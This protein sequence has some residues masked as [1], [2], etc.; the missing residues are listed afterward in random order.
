MSTIEQKVLRTLPVAAGDFADLAESL[1]RSTVQVWGRRGASGS[2]VVWKRDGLVI[3][4]SHVVAE[5]H[6]QVRLA[7]G[8]T[9]EAAV[10]GRDRVRDLAALKVTAT[11]LPAVTVGD[12]NSLRA[13][14]VVL[15][16]GNPTGH[17][18]ALSTGIVHAAGRRWI[19]ADLRLAPGN[20]GGPLA[21]AR[22]EV[23]GI[24]SMIAGGL[25]LAV[26]SNEVERFLLH[27][28]SDKRPRLGI[29]VRPLPVPIGAQKVLGLIVISVQESSVAETAGLLIGD[30]LLGVDGRLFR[31]P[32]DLAVAL[33]DVSTER[34][35]LELDLIRSG[36]R[37]ILVANLS[38]E[39]NSAEAV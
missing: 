30:T 17:V 29:I 11:D 1:R 28:G 9:F 18:G 20:S 33:N 34:G 31:D 26:P 38:K 16:V 23:I 8:R 15:A 5:N 37:M 36:K 35:S 7:D 13:G 22:G 12:S 39:N 10:T 6:V 21:S 2:G 27:K 14:E 24:N 4:N 25:A 19:Q 32:D 3:T